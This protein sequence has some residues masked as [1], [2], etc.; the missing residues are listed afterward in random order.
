MTESDASGRRGCPPRRLATTLWASS[1]RPARLTL[2]ELMVL[3]ACV[4]EEKER[5]RYLEFVFGWYYDRSRTLRAVLSA[6][7]L[8]I[9]IA[10]LRSPLSDGKVIAGAGVACA[11]TLVY[12]STGRVL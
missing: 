2:R 10:A 6:S 7:S 9:G 5:R 3:V 8:A 11:L 4:S 1:F 12:V